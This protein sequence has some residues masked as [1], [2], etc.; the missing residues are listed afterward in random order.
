LRLF[1]AAG[2]YKFPLAAPKDGH[3]AANF[4][5]CSS[6]SFSFSLSVV[7]CI[8]KRKTGG[9][10]ERERALMRAAFERRAEQEREDDV[11]ISARRA[12]R[13]APVQHHGKVASFKF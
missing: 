4:K 11:I 2:E 7:R 3:F 13:R 1:V 6:I 12:R 5:Q 8:R 10:E 9:D